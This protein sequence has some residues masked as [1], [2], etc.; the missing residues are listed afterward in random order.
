M[1]NNELIVVK[2]LGESSN[3]AKVISKYLASRERMRH[4][5]DTNRLKTYLKNEGEKIDDK[6]FDKYWKD[7]DA[8]ELGS[9]DKKGRFRWHYNLKTV[10][11]I[12]SGQETEDKLEKLGPKKPSVTTGA[13]RGRPAGSTKKVENVSKVGYFF[14][15]QLLFFPMDMSG[16][17]AEKIAKFV[18][19]IPNLQR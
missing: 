9:L 7:A 8:S 19:T 13:K 17:E 10:G 2:K 16:A 18:T 12:A 6:E 15:N 1:G 14:R 5:T 4:E 3:T 11:Q